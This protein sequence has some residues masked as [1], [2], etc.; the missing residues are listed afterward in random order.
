MTLFGGIRKGTRKKGNPNYMSINYVDKRGRPAVKYVKRTSPEA[1]AEVQRM[2]AD[3]ASNPFA[4]AEIV[5]RA[6]P[7]DSSL[8]DAGFRQNPDGSWG[9]GGKF[10]YDNFYDDPYGTMG[11]ELRD[12][13][14]RYKL[15]AKLSKGLD[16]MR[17]FAI[18]LGKIS[19]NPGRIGKK[20]STLEK[21][22]SRTVDEWGTLGV[23]SH[24]QV[25]GSSY[26]LNCEIPSAPSRRPM[27]HYGSD[28]DYGVSA[29]LDFEG[30]LTTTYRPRPTPPG[31]SPKEYAQWVDQQHA[32]R[33][34][35][36]K[37]V[38]PFL[39]KIVAERVQR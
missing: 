10:A 38:E 25:G 32:E 36:A 1:Q 30:N 37:N 12:G 16:N 33:E 22:S 9:N 28:D 23:S 15:T 27:L 13:R 21:N 4:S 29:G 17:Q 19:F 26:S 31:L 35:Y 20:N 11:A 6:Q 5:A 14:E 8:R 39:K 18:S 3:K 7:I 34:H 24:E 2:R